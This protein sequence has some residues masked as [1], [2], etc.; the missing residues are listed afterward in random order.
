[1]SFLIA[2]G[3]A[4]ENTKRQEQGYRLKSL[5]C[6]DPVMVEL[7]HIPTG[8]LF[9]MGLSELIANAEI[10]ASLPEKDRTQIEVWAVRH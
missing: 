8:R 9:P 1:M 7:K 10:M 2:K 5:D 3:A 4:M 6:S